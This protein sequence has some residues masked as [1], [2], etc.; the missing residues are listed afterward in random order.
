MHVHPLSKP[1]KQILEGP[2]SLLL[3]ITFKIC[4]TRFASEPISSAGALV[5]GVDAFRSYSAEALSIAESSRGSV[6]V[7]PGKRK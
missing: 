1:S 4:S 2:S 3:R 7:Y 5:D 6:I